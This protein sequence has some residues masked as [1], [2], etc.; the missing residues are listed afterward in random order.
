MMKQYKRLVKLQLDYSINELKTLH[1]LKKI[2]RDLELINK[3]NNIEPN[4]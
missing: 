2:Q 1:K 3:I 4:A